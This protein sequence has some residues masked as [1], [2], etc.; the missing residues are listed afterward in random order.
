MFGSKHIHKLLL[1]P[2]TYPRCGKDFINQR[3][4]TFQSPT[5]PKPYKAGT[6]CTWSISVPPGRYVQVTFMNVDLQGRK[7]LIP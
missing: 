5:Y 1:E 6:H 2:G 7:K 4:G 3:R